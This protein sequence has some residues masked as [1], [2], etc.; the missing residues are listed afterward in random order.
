MADIVSIAS[1]DTLKELIQQ[2]FQHEPAWMRERR[3][4]AAEAYFALDW[5]KL[6]RTP[7]KKRRLDQIPVFN[8]PPGSNHAAPVFRATDGEVKI[9]LVN[10]QVVALSVPSALTDRGLVLKPLAESLGEAP[11]QEHLG[12]IIPDSDDKVTA[13]TAALWQNGVYLHVP[14]GLRETVQ[15]SIESEASQQLPALLTRNLIVCERGTHVIITERL[16]SEDGADKMLLSEHTEIVVGAGAKVQ[17]GAIQQCSSR[18]E[19]F[20]HRAGQI[21][22]D[23]TLEWN[24]GEFGAGLVVSDHVSHLNEPGALTKSVTVFFGSGQ[25]HQDYT[26]KSYHHAPH[27]TSDMVARGVM[28]DRSRSVFTGLTQIEKGAKGTDGR[29]REQTLMLSDEARADAIPS[30][31]IDERDVYAAHAASAG[32]VDRAALFYLTS[33][34]LTEEE[35]ERMIVHGFLAPVID[36]IPVQ[37][38]RSEVWDAVERKIRE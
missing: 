13:L 34:G 12:R 14:A 30:L 31:L 3:L 7:L 8:A 22:Q 24:I 19:G 37:E 26:A 15:V 2:R 20:I 10:N 9:H 25:Q 38:L 1:D 5:P 4:T 29:Q 36:S 33:R 35:A 28:K 23:G 18:V 32:P 16:R 11:V 21:A 27:T 17:Y 6:S